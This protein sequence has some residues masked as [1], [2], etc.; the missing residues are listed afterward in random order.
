MTAAPNAQDRPAV[1]LIHGLWM[2]P[3]SW[4][5]WIDRYTA[6][7]HR[8]LAPA[9]PGLEDG[10]EAVRRDPSALAGLGVEE[11]LAHYERVIGLLERPPILIGHSFGGAFVQLLLDRGLGSAGVAVHPAPL[12]GILQLPFSTIRS[13]W[14]VLGSPANRRRPVALTPAQ[15]RYAFTNTLTEEE[16]SAVYERHHVPAASRVLFQGALA[17][18]NPKAATRVDWANSDRA[19]LLL[20]AGDADHTVPA[21]VVRA[22][23][24][25][26]RNS[27]AITEYQEFPGR[28]HYTLGQPGWEQVADLALDWATAHAAA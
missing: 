3:R 17:N 23:L 19:P 9:W 5:Q 2:T 28:S 21:S 1:V 20:I 18:F 8:V 10:V 13:A 25:K 7:G 14:P 4:E 6:Q 16:S 11:I 24:R 26:Y 15:F 27:G 12:K 22:N